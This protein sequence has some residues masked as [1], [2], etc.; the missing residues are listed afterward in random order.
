MAAQQ[1][2]LDVISNNL[3]NVN[4]SGFKKARVDF[5]DLIYQTLR[6]SGAD[7]A[8]GSEMPVGQQ[9][10]LGTRAIS[11]QKLFT[12]GEFKQTGNPLDMAIEGKGFFQVLTPSGEL[13][14]TRDGAFKTDSE[15]RLVT[16]DGY[17][18]Q[19][20][21]T[22][23]ANYQ[24]IVVGVDGTVS[25]VLPGQNEAQQ[26]GQIQTVSF[27]NPAGLSNEGH[28]LYRPTASSGDAVTGTPGQDGLG[29]LAS[30]ILEMSNVQ[31]VE[32]MVNMIIAQRAYEINSKAV[33]S[34]D[35][36]LRIANSL[37]Q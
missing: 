7:Q 19:P 3:A 13:A 31:V 30:G 35:E 33:Q 5:Q 28:N 4:T 37:R 8:Q 14:Y 16:S 36:M 18:L 1:L 34:A 6:P 26:L 2:Q 17:L 20:E 9:I 32:E 23:P 10:G 11:V 22:I 15:G 27:S 29:G 25:V 24:E 21:I 12:T